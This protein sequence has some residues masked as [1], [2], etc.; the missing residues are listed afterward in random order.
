MKKERRFCYNHLLFSEVIFLPMNHSYIKD[1]DYEKEFLEKLLKSKPLSRKIYL[2][3]QRKIARKYKIPFF[4]KDRL[5]K[6]YHTLVA[7]NTFP[8][9]SLMESLL[10]LKSVRSLSGIVV[11]SV[12]TKP[13]LCPGNC[14]YCPTEDNA[15]KS[16]IKDEP[17]VMRAIACKYDPLKQVRA[18]IK[19]LKATGHPT[20]KINIRVIGGTWSYYNKQYQTWFI[21]KCFSACNDIH[22]EGVDSMTLAELQKINETS[23]NRIVEISIETRQDYINKGEIRRLRMLGV[24]KVE[25]GVQS[26][27]DSVLGL[28]NRGH[29]NEATITATK[30][31]RDA[32][33]KVSY[34]MMTNLPGSDI[35]RDQEMFLELFSNQIY[36]PDYLKIYPLALV[37]EAQIY[38][39]YKEGK[40][41]PHDQE[42]LKLLLKKIKKELPY[43]ARVERIIRDIPAGYIVEGGAK[44]SNMRQIVQEE[45]AKEGNACKCIRCREVKQ[46]NENGQNVQLYRQDYMAGG[47]L[48]IF[49]SYESKDR[50]HLHS[51]LRLRI[52]S[53]YYEKKMHFLKILNGSAIIREVHSFGQQVRIDNRI[54]GASQHKGLGRKLISKAEEIAKEEFGVNKIAVI[55]G[56]GVREYFRKQGFDLEDTYMVKNL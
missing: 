31:L 11:V 1:I 51:L 49:L 52:P 18:R 44:V 33:F 38:K 26:I 36:Q 12:L 19:A 40:F 27:Y 56:V 45:M 46:N 41:K 37:K 3:T 39:L 28:N 23:E 13:Y 17:A 48:E 24:T 25:L 20:D 8:G 47:G 30:L 9:S 34:Q 10:R 53:T 14:L 42:Q 21:K 35:K 22:T 15:P 16:Y 2:E 50:K 6:K 54:K 32:G 43:Y 55:S 29:T 4:N 7:N 5:I